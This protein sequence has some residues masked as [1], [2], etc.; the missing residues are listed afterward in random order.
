[1]S[2]IVPRPWRSCSRTCTWVEQTITDMAEAVQAALPAAAKEMIATS[3]WLGR[4]ILQIEK[5]PLGIKDVC[6][7]SVWLHPILPFVPKGKLSPLFYAD[8][9]LH[10]DEL[11]DG[12]LLTGMYT[13]N[14]SNRKG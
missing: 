10:L 3:G 11:F 13:K 6:Q 14:V 8:M 1:M 5:R 7:N 4:R 9:F 12:Q 2:E